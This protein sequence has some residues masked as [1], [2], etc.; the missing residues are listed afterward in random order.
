MKQITVIGTGYVGLVSG[1]LLSEFG[2][3]VICV[4]NDEKKIDSLKNN[5]CPIYEPGLEEFLIKNKKN[6]KLTFTTDLEYAVKKAEVIFIAVGTPSL[7][8]GSADLSYVF[9][10]AKDIG[11]YINGYKVIVDKSTVPIG[12]GRKVHKI[13]QEEIDKRAGQIEFDVVSNPEF[14]REGSAVYDFRHPDRIVI[15]TESEKALEI[16]KDVYSVLYLNKSPFIECNIETAE[17][18]KYANNAYLATKISFINEIANLCEKVGAN[19]QKVAEAMGKDGRISPKFLHP[20]PGY[21]GSCFPKDTRAIVRIARENHENLSIIE[22]AVHAND[23]QKLRMAD[24]VIRCMNGVDNKTVTVLGITFKPET[25][26]MREAP[27]LVIIRELVK[28][29]A[30]IKIY[31]PEGEKEARIYFQDILH[32]LEFCNDEYEAMEASEAVII[33]TEWNVFRNLDLARMKKLL[34][35]NYFF[36]FRNIYNRSKIEQLGFQYTGVGV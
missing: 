11:R 33:L 22:A 24:K 23:M 29:G 32:S 12:T 28:N 10:V 26:D 27:S 7:G 31:D 13:I 34:K 20:G 30:K 9:K 16:M 17:M 35:N 8:D 4:D 18:I 3:Q 15:G 36:D 19:V 5:K 1:V 14:L 21:G 6:K 2:N 25:D